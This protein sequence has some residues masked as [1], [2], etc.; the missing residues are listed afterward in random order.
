MC[1]LSLTRR[2]LCCKPALCGLCGGHSQ[3]LWQWVLGEERQGAGVCEAAEVDWNLEMEPG[4]W[5]CMLEI[6]PSG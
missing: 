1:T 2:A 6:I 5:A 4:T 3:G